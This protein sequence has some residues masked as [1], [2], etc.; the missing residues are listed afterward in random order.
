[1]LV[2]SA[3]LLYVGTIHIADSL[4]SSESSKSMKNQYAIS[5]D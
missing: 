3:E 1:M 4:T 5:L 2:G